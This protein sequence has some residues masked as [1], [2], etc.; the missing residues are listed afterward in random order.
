M[1]ELPDER[2]RLDELDERPDDPPGARRDEPID[3]RRIPVRIAVVFDD[4]RRFGRR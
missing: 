2:D 1:R 3:P 4:V